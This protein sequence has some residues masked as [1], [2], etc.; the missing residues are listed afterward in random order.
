MEDCE[1]QDTDEAGSFCTLCGMH[2]VRGGLCE[3]C[4]ETAAWQGET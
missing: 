4:R 1:S 2:G 3:R